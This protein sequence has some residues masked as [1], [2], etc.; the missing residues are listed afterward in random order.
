[1]DLNINTMNV[2]QNP[3]FGLVTRIQ[4]NKKAFPN[5]ENVSECA[6]IFTKALDA[7][8]HD[9]HYGLSGMLSRQKTANLLES[10]SYFFAKGVM[11]GTGLDYSVEWASQ[12]IGLPIKKAIDENY[13]NFFVFTGEHI[14]LFKKALSNI[15]T[16]RQYSKEAGRQYPNDANRI[17]LYTMVKYGIEGDKILDIEGANSPT[18]IITID[19]IDELGSFVDKLGIEST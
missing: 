18:E 11:A 8:T 2:N 1:M 3:N 7:I 17:L 14:K 15:K 10:M 13:H 12:N 6:D 5:P 19:S 4:V 9:S 16:I